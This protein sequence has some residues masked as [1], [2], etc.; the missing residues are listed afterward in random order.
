MPVGLSLLDLSLPSAEENLALDEAL[1]LELEDSP[2]PQGR[3]TLRLWEPR[4]MIAVVGRGSRTGE[5]VRLDACRERSTPVLRR[6]SGGAA[7]VSGPGCLMYSVV[8][9]L[10]LRPHLKSVEEA[11]R[12]VLGTIC[13]GLEPLVPGIARKGTSDLA[14]GPRKVSGNSLQIKRKA[15]LYHG[16]LLYDFPLDL[17]ETLLAM[18]PRVPDYREARSHGDFVANLPVPVAALRAA[19]VEAWQASATRTDWPVERVRALV[20]EKYAQEEWNLR[21]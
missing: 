1:L 19:L 21:R 16:T 8:L 2:A 14:L 9:S 20:V 11:H 3:E 18:P 10:D 6:T 4:Q 12:F 15:L 7:I 5:E 17:I 13:R